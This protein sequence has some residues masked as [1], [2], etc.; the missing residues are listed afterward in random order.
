MGLISLWVLGV[1]GNIPTESLI[2]KVTFEKKR[3]YLFYGEFVGL[4]GTKCKSCS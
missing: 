3:Y 1:K 4:G 2:Q